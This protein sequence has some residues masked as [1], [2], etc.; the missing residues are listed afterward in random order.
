MTSLRKPIMAVV[1]LT[2]G[3]ICL[4]LALRDI[5]WQEVARIVRPAEPSYIV[6]GFALQGTNLLMRAVR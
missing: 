6:L 2:V 1:G 3:S 5:D 4:W